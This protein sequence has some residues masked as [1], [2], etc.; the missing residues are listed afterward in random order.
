MQTSTAVHG[1]VDADPNERAG[2]QSRSRAF[3]IAA[4]AGA[5]PAFVVDA[6]FVNLGRANFLQRPVFANVYDAQARTLFHGHWNV[7]PAVMGFEG[8][9]I[10]GRT[11]SY[12]G[13]FPALLRMPILAVTSRFDGRLTQLSMLAAF[14]VALFGIARLLWRARSFVRPDAPF[15][16][17]EGVVTAVFLFVCGVGSAVL[18]PASRAIIYHEAEVWGTALALV[19]FDAVIGAFRRRSP[20]RYA[21]ASFLAACALLSRPSVGLGPAVALGIFSLIA[22]WRAVRRTDPETTRRWSP[23]LAFGAAAAMPVLLYAYVN[24]TKFGTWFSLPLDK[25]LYST[26]NPSRKAALAANGGSLFSVKYIPST[27]WQYLRPDAL[28][29]WRVAPFVDFPVRHASVFLGERFD[30][31]DRSSSVV[32]SMPAL[33]LLAIAGVVVLVRRLRT[34]TALAFVVCTVAAAIAVFPTLA[35]G[36][37]AN[38]YLIDFVPLLIVPAVVAIQSGLA[39][40]N[41]S[42]RRSQPA[43]RA[44]APIVIG[45]V[46]VAL[47]AFQLWTNAGITLTYQ[48][49][50]AAPDAQV[51]RGFAGWQEAVASTVGTGGYRV[52]RLTSLPAK[53]PP[54]TL[55]IVGRCDGLYFGDPHYV[56]A[57]L[58]VGPSTHV[59]T[60]VRF[61]ADARPGTRQSLVVMPGS[62]GLNVSVVAEGSDRFRFE[63][64]DAAGHASTRS[65]ITV[66]VDRT[67]TVD[68]VIDP[69]IRATRV[70]VDGRTALDAQGTAIPAGTAQLVVPAAVSA[71]VR[72]VSPLPVTT[73]LCDRVRRG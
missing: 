7:P 36:F 34:D 46:A 14:A 24:H 35:L 68:V 13:P 73:P 52:L 43:R 42:A 72:D 31:L 47:A 66:P 57:Q 23:V 16:R 63:V 33:A 65:A 60:R 8:F 69:A 19:G 39:V 6:W 5:L 9:V 20:A 62:P 38:R 3:T 56:W 48:R 70:A 10:H 58:E 55:A 37:I 41:G 26:F 15:T 28:R 40:W 12:Y 54:D 51:L 30:T 1:Q 21:L 4:L 45:G 27:V 22:A 18:F 64:V 11:Y 2:E 71:V 17:L 49:M 32:A 29:F 61:V 44:R 53:P 50:W 25:Q 59:R 67:A